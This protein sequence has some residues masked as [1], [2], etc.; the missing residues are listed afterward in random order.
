MKYDKENYLL[1]TMR[2]IVK[3]IKSN[4]DLRR[5]GISVN[6]SF[7]LKQAELLSENNTKYLKLPII[8]K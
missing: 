8:K 5:H 6:T 1:L 7:D 3:I 2:E 4:S